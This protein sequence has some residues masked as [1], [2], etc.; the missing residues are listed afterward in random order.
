MLPSY[1]PTAPLQSS[2]VNHHRL[3]AI[4]SITHDGP[5]TPHA[6]IGE[7]GRSGISI[8]S[9]LALFAPP[10]ALAT[11]VPAPLYLF[12]FIPG[13]LAHFY[14][15]NAD[16]T[17]RDRDDHFQERVLTFATGLTITVRAVGS[18]RHGFPMQHDADI[19]LGLLRLADQGGVAADGTITEPS[20]RS[21]L[22]AAGRDGARSGDDVTAVKRALARWTV[23]VETEAIIDF[24]DLAADLRTGAARL[25]F[26]PNAPER[27]TR[28]SAYPVLEYSYDA[29]VRRGTTIDTIGHLQINPIWLSQ[30]HAGIASWIDVD[31][32][33]RIRSPWAKRIYQH[34]ASRA[35]LGWHPNELL[36]LSLR[37]FLQALAVRTGRRPA[38]DAKSI[39][40]ALEVLEPLGVVQPSLV[41]RHR[42]G[43]Y[44][45]VIEGG[46][47]LVG[48]HRLRGATTQDTV[49][50]RMLLT[51]LKAY[52]INDRDG[53]ELVR[54]HP[55]PVLSAL[56]YLQYRA[57]APTGKPIVHPAQWI[58][59]AIA[60]GYLFEE[61]AY[62]RW[63]E[64]KTKTAVKPLA[65]PAARTSTRVTQE[66]NLPPTT[67]SFPATRWGQVIE[68]L[69]ADGVVTEAAAR[70][71]LAGAILSE[72]VD[73]TV[74]L[75]APDPFA[76]AWITSRYLT[77]LEQFLSQVFGQPIH[78]IVTSQLDSSP[79]DI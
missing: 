61:P 26:P 78:A 20:Y 13:T 36:V 27:T 2:R 64:T 10:T 42:K 76:V 24:R 15:T 14:P 54:R 77:S 66:N 43:V 71:F 57:A 75:R 11:P 1:L 44:D 58:R 23:T 4:R 30:A 7:G 72:P 18:P 5:A 6:R 48:A 62:K 49:L 50:S 73:G 22:R 69:I 19:M 32:H 37:D 60:D 45:V 40:G 39:Q 53:R 25:P 16:G 8:T 28:T 67:Q 65:L 52:G 33:N 12:E 56:R 38:E 70:M 51:H 63:L 31:I 21:I 9:P 47:Q 68:S 74:T 34:L 41:R 35:A 46:E 3:S 17:L 59:R 79:I 55:A 29:E